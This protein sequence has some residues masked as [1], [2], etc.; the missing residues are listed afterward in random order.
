LAFDRQLLQGPREA[1]GPFLQRIAN[2]FDT[3]N[4]AGAADAVLKQLQIYAQGYQSVDLPQFVIVSNPRTLENGDTVVSWW[5]VDYDD[6]IGAEPLLSNT[7]ASIAMPVD[8]TWDDG[9]GTWRNWLVVYQYLDAPTSTGSSAAITTAGG[10]SF[11]EDD[12]GHNVGGVWVPKTSGTPVNAPFLTVTGLTGLALENIGS[13]L[14]VSGSAHPTNN[15]TF[16]IVD[17]LSA[18]SCVIANPVGVAADAGPLTW[19]VASYPWIPP[20]LA[21]GSPGQVW[22][23]GEGLAPPIDLGSNRGG[24]WQPT[25][26]A[27][28][29]AQPLYSWGLQINSLEIQTIRGLVKTW[30]SAG[31]YYPN[32]IICYDGP[33]GAYNRTHHAGSGNPDGTFGDIG[34]LVAG[35]WVPTRLIYSNLDCYCQGTGRA[36][37][38]SLENVT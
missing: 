15:G 9:P 12:L 8:F 28:A 29:G 34:T 33:Q 1:D 13:M 22:G 21:F 35:V 17:V 31:T 37:A 2:A 16:Q 36:A 10:G 38:C 11:V 32:I 5:T 30:K 6:P 19:A 25:E 18:T 26:L 7:V 27:S 4:H 20:G 14:T 24:V 23:A 3:W